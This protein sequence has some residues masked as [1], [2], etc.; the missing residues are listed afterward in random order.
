MSNSRAS[1]L[2]DSKYRVC[3]AE[4]GVRQC[5]ATQKTYADRSC[6]EAGGG[7]TQ[8]SP[9]MSFEGG[10]D[11]C[12]MEFMSFPLFL[13]IRYLKP[14]KSRST[15]VTLIAVLGV[16]LGVA[17]LIIVR[18]V[19]TGF[20]DMWREKILSFKP[21]VTVVSSKGYIPDAE[22]I[23]SVVRSVE[24]VT[25]VSPSIET[26]VLAEHDGYLQAPLMVGIEPGGLSSLHP[27]LHSCVIAGTPSL[28][29]GKAILGE[30]LARSLNAGPGDK[31]VVYSPA[32]LISE[33]EVYFP[34]EVEISAV[35]RMGQ[36]SFDGGYI[37]T[38]ISFMRDLMDIPAGGAYSVHVKTAFPDDSSKFPAVMAAVKDGLPEHFLVRSWQDID[39][40]LFS[41]IAVEKNM[42]AVLLA[43]ITVVAIFC[44]V[45]TI[46]VI[47]VRKTPEI[48]L[49]KA[50]GFTP[51]RI[52]AAFVVYG[53]VQCVVG[54]VL[55]VALAW[56]VL[57]NLQGIVDML[58]NF[59]LEVFPKGVY[60]LDRIPWRVEAGEIA[61]TVLAVVLACFAASLLPSWRAASKNPAEAFRL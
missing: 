2:E 50:I 9:G 25:A 20:G 49:M 46:I 39:R 38:S 53:L 35:Y 60:G 5:L 1:C 16:V 52:S 3:F 54:A 36:A 42:M 61:Q 32:N 34:E 48:G 4:S 22:A 15:A 37:I 7:R 59:G 56:L 26:R 21:H 12:I 55:G 13:A 43:F 14:N 10:L 40:D 29:D 47:T 31:V 11:Y 44:V 30:D 18:A 6:R 28:D 8:D 33:D 24:G 19:M 41:A 58:G 17:I 23:S 51:W 45:N 57:A 27:D